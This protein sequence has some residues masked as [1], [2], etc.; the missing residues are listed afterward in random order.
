LYLDIDG[1][2]TADPGSVPGV[3]TFHVGQAIVDWIPELFYPLVEK[4]DVVWATSWILYPEMLDELEHVFDVKF[5][6]VDLNKGE[7]F[8][9]YSDVSCGKLP[10][11]QRHYEADPAE[12]LWID[13]HAGP[14]DQA[15]A[16]S[17]G[18]KMLIPDYYLGGAYA[19]MLEDDWE[20]DLWEAWA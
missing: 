5:P 1:V 3:R 4:F 14:T 15:W 9:N 12:F 20:P 19:M 18:G 7:Y 17:E 10:A 13:D 8:L 16:T 11:V 6:R 2:I